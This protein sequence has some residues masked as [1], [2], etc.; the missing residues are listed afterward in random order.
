MFAMCLSK[1]RAR[2]GGSHYVKY[3]SDHQNNFLCLI[4]QTDCICKDWIPSVRIA[5]LLYI[6]PKK[7]M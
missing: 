1:Q 5:F 7:L 3:F 6:G 4:Y 2:T